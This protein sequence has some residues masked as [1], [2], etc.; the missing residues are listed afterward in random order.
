MESLLLS[1]SFYRIFSSFYFNDHPLKKST[2]PHQRIHTNTHTNKPE[3]C[4]LS[5]CLNG[6]LIEVIYASLPFFALLVVVEIGKSA[7]MFW[8][9]HE[10]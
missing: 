9:Q 5:L 8:T 2:L 10:A 7:W 1:C 4:S 6:H 3:Q